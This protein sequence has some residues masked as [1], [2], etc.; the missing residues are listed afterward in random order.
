MKEMIR[1]VKESYFLKYNDIFALQI[2]V[3]VVR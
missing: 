1:E 2:Y 3:K